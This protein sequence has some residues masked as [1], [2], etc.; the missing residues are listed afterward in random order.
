MIPIL[1]DAPN[2]NE[3]MVT[4]SKVGDP[5]YPVLNLPEETPESQLKNLGQNISPETLNMVGDT[6]GAELRP[7]LAESTEIPQTSP[8]GLSGTDFNI[9]PFSNLESALPKPEAQMSSKKQ[10]PPI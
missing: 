3:I 1:A 6:P 8:T 9:S 2:Q 5:D 4:P 10:E 7:T